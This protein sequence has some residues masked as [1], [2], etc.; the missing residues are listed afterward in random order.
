MEPFM[1]AYVKVD[2]IFQEDGQ[3]RPRAIYWE[4]VAYP[5]DRVLSIDRAASQRVGGQGD[6]YRVKVL[7][8]DRYLFFEHATDQTTSAKPGRWFVE[9]RRIPLL[10]Y[11]PFPEE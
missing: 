3:M 4:G 6:R 7:G 2:V 10:K 1:K 11:P 8:Q 9:A 5:V